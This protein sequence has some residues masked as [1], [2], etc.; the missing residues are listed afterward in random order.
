[1]PMS[2]A[3]YRAMST[4]TQSPSDLRS[5]CVTPRC[6]WRHFR[7][8]AICAESV[9]ESTS[10]TRLERGEVHQA[11]KIELEGGRHFQISVDYRAQTF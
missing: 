1:M 4:E 9:D 5:T 6:N 2:A 11:A 10:I 8:L 3:I 7:T